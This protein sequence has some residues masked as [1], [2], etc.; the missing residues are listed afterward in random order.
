MHDL[1]GKRV[2]ELPLPELGN[3]SGSAYDIDKD[4]VY[5]TL[6]TF[7]A[8]GKLYQ[9]DGKTLAWSLLWEDKPPL[10]TTQI[11]TKARVLSRPRTVRAFR[12]SCP[13][14]RE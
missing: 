8:P 3:I 12:C 14:A 9:I 2:R 10:D 13:I 6:S 5:A 1:S 7:T 4:V 11:E